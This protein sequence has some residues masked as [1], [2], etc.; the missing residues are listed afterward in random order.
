[1]RRSHPQHDI[2]VFIDPRTRTNTAII[3]CNSLLNYGHEEGILLA[4]LQEPSQDSSSGSQCR[5]E[6]FEQFD[7]ACFFAER[8]D[9]SVLGELSPWNTAVLQYLHIRLAFI[10]H[11]SSCP[12]AL[13]RLIPRFPWGL[14][15]GA[16]NAILP[17]VSIYSDDTEHFQK[18]SPAE[19]DP[20]SEDWILQGHIWTARYFPHDWFTGFDERYVESTY[21]FGGQNPSLRC[22]IWESRERRRRIVYL[23]R[24][25]AQMATPLCFNTETASF[26]LLP[27]RTG[28]LITQ[29]HVIKLIGSSPVYKQTT[30]QI[31]KLWYPTVMP[32][33]VLSSSQRYRRLLQSMLVRVIAS[34]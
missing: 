4:R 18:T 24:C 13:A 19:A 9:I 2:S 28:E 14:V 25:L 1:M 32:C 15:R 29:R 8:T 3:I 7:Q 6:L 30:L 34:S 31:I 5:D 33:R 20:L 21:E 17:T 22:R 10:H 27:D 11:F 16:L 26:G 23:G 12:P